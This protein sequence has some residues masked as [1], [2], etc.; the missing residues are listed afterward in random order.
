[1]TEPIAEIKDR[2]VQRLREMPILRDEAI[3]GY[4]REEGDGLMFG[5][6]ERPEHLELFAVDGV[7]ESFGADLLPEDFAAVEAN[8][9]AA[10]ELVPALGR[11]GIRRNVRGPFQMTADEM[12]LA[13]PAW[14]LGNF[15]LAEGV[16]GG[17]L[18][19]GALGHYL[20]AWIVEG[21]A[22]IDMSEIDPRRFG[23]HCNKAWTKIKVKQAWGLHADVRF[24][25]QEWSGARPQK[26]APSFDRLSELGA[27]WGNLNGW[28]IPNWFAPEGVPRLDEYSF[29]RAK[30]AEHVA[31]EVDAVRNAVG[32]VEMT[33]M[34]KFEVNGRGA[35]AW[36]ARTLANRLPG[37]GRA[38]LSHHLSARGTVQSEYVVCRLGDESFYL[39]STPRGQ[40]LNLDLLTGTLPR[41][42]SVTLRDASLERG[43]FTVVGP[44][45]RELLQNLTELNLS[46]EHFP[47]LSARSATVGLATDVRLIRINYEGELGWELYHPICY[48]R[49]LLDELLQYGQSLG[50]RLVGLHALESLRLDKSYRA[51]YRDMNQEHTALESSLDRFLDLAKDGF[52]GQQALL[53]QKAAG[54]AKRLV[55][56]QI[57][58]G[59]AP[60]NSNESIYCHGRLAGRVSSGAYSYHLKADLA[61]AYVDI[62][63]AVSGQCLEVSIMNARREAVVIPDSPYDPNNSRIKA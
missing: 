35:A 11:T 51:M 25:Y 26:T 54:L 15:W 57:S 46:N 39:I 9:M 23:D 21:D 31:A 44:R 62:E 36:L 24:P 45:S 60:A 12:P 3:A 14:G 5:P 38:A 41:D 55:T 8:W 37:N 1:I 42:G 10:A 63:Q 28:E 13:G 47:W 34:T 22:G 48:Q 52:S 58:P 7:P 29:R 43:C 2:K 33:P 18:W 59:D 17:I 30:N 61:L 40:R 20:S 6:Y 50:I 4:I 32:L 53:T 49:H 16:P 56:L 27:V 19:G